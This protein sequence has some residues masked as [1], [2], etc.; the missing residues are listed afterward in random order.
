MIN[1]DSLRE[2]PKFHQDVRFLFPAR[3]DTDN[4]FLRR[5]SS[6]LTTKFPVKRN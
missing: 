6:F 1:F 3:I 4:N 5:S 2:T